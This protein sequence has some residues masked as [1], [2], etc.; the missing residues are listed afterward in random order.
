MI[1]RM[2]RRTITAWMLWRAR[3]SLRRALPA[4][5][6]L[7]S[8]KAAL[9]SQHKAGGRKIDVERKRVVTERLMHELGRV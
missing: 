1:P 8:R 3:R 5:A 6:V 9:R 4:L 7:D 2:I